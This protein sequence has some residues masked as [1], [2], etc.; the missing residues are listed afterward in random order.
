MTSAEILRRL[1]CASGMW[2]MLAVLAQLT[3]IHD[4]RAYKN[5]FISLKKKCP[6]AS[7]SYYLIC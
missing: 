4:Q 2:L 3:L 7:Q 6:Q 5:K 1:G